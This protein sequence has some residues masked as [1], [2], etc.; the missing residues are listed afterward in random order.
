[1]ESSNLPK[2]QYRKSDLKKQAFLIR[3]KIASTKYLEVYCHLNNIDPNTFK[4]LNKKRI[5][6]IKNLPINYFW[7]ILFKFLIQ[8]SSLNIFSKETFYPINQ[9][10]KLRFKLS[11]IRN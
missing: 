11:N 7:K 3:K 4:K 8:K 6:Y 5:N 2:N 9:A 10:K 1:M